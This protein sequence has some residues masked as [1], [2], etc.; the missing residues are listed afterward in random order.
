MM[1][2]GPVHFGMA[3]NK[4]ELATIGTGVGTTLAEAI[5]EPSQ[6]RVHSREVVCADEKIE[7]GLVPQ[8]EVGTRDRKKRDALQGR[9][10]DSSATEFSRNASRL[11]ENAR[12]APAIV[13]AILPQAGPSPCRQKR[14][15]SATLQRVEKIERK[16]APIEPV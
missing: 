9:K 6:P 15:A 13:V 5:A 1:R 4:S 16:A 12:V 8:A 2:S 10:D 14:R 7:I 11:R 3:R